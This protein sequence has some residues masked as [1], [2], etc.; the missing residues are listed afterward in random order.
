MQNDWS[1]G[2]KYLIIH[3]YLDITWIRILIF[4][5]ISKFLKK[6]KLIYPKKYNLLI[7]NIIHTAWK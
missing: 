3:M 5:F 7:T 6:L 4:E 2:Y 1:D